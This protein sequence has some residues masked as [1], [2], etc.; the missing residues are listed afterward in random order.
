MGNYYYYHHKIVHKV[1]IRAKRK[2]TYTLLTP[3]VTDITHNI[4][5]VPIR[6]SYSWNM[7]NITLKHNQL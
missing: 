6:K 2:R 5:D 4:I 1:H 7:Q 3:I